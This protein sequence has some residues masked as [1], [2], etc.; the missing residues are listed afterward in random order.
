PAHHLPSDIALDFWQMLA[1][2]GRSQE[3]LGTAALL[4]ANQFDRIV[5]PSPAAGQP[6]GGGLGRVDS[7]NSLAAFAPKIIGQGDNRDQI[8]LASAV[9]GLLLEQQ[10]WEEASH[11]TQDVI[12]SVADRLTD[13]HRPT[14]HEFAARL[15]EEEPGSRWAG[16]LRA[17]EEDGGLGSIR[18]GVQRHLVRHGDAHR[19]ERA[20]AAQRE[21]DQA[22][23]A[24]RRAAPR[25]EPPE[26]EAYREAG[27]RFR[28]LGQ[29]VGRILKDVEL[30]DETDLSR[31]PEAPAPP[32]VD[33]S[34]AEVRAAVYGAHWWEQL[35]QRALRSPDHLVPHGQPV[36][37]DPLS[38][39]RRPRPRPIVDDT[40]VFQQLFE[41]VLTDQRA[42]DLQH[43]EAWLEDWRGYWSDEIAPFREWLASDEESALL[44]PEL[45]TRRMHD[46]E[47]LGELL[48][49]LDVDALVGQV[50]ERAPAF[51]ESTAVEPGHAFPLQPGHALPWHAESDN[52]AREADERHR[53]PL[54]VLQMRAAIADAAADRVG[55]QLHGL[56]RRVLQ[57]FRDTF[58]DV[59]ESLLDQDAFRPAVS[60]RTPG[61][62][63]ESSAVA[64]PDAGEPDAGERA[65][66][67]DDLIRKW[68][69]GER[70]SGG[71][72]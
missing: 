9:T 11:Q 17:Y 23:R 56:L 30:L 3:A 64:E 15:E 53:H 66:T 69:K 44:L 49:G 7:L 41:R 40:T 28:E 45:Y 71:D 2:D 37:R 6:G 8:F 57:V 65:T 70:G 18:E 27:A 43:L 52:G 1:A 59:R 26:A 48:D 31:L 25:D 12:R 24:Y 16:R 4:A 54:A 62:A 34:R 67:I 61:R 55:A 21:V 42:Q 29:L 13:I 39:G 63:E 10:P 35:F 22:L 33:S 46:P 19:L 38:F 68:L 60:R 5:V 14:W 58:D 32:D 51:L 20:R 50:A 36:E 72:V 47:I